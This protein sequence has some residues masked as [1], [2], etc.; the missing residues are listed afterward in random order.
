MAKAT[1]PPNSLPS[2]LWLIT[3]SVRKPR[4][5]VALDVALVLDLAGF[6]LLPGKAEAL[7]KEVLFPLLV[8]ASAVGQEGCQGIEHLLSVGIR[9]V[10]LVGYRV[11]RFARIGIGL[12]VFLLAPLDES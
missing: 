12:G 2:G 10:G 6:D 11:D 9:Q 7:E 3:C 8:G 4:V 1:E 5:R